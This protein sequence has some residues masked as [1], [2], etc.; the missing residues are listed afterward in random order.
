MGDHWRRLAQ[1]AADRGLLGHLHRCPALAEQV[2]YPLAGLRVATANHRQA[3]VP[4][5]VD[6]IGAAAGA[7][8]GLHGRPTQQ[9]TDELRD[10]LWPE[11]GQQAFHDR[12]LEHFDVAIAGVV[13]IDAV[14]DEQE[15]R[16]HGN[17]RSSVSSAP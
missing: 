2:A 13:G 16:K 6:G 17:T 9:T 14:T 7:P 3:L 5:L 1:L 11:I 8:P 4:R 15:T 12:A 10:D